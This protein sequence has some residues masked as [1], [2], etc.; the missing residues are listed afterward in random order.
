MHPSPDQLV[1]KNINIGLHG[2]FCFARLLVDT[3]DHNLITVRLQ[4]GMRGAF[5]KPNGLVARV[6]IG[7]VLMSIRSKEDKI[8]HAVA[9]LRRAKYKFPG[10]QKVFVSEKWGFTR[11]TKEEYKK[12]QSEGRVVS[13]GVNCKWISGRGRLSNTFPAAKSITLPNIEN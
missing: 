6:N 3:L 9:A 1:D 7:Q 8:Q 13:D 5:G 11:F 12:Y 10:R 4:T 2:R